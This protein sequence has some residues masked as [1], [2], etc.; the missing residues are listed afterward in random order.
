M[1][2]STRRR[3]AGT[4]G[5][6]SRRSLRSRA[7]TATAVAALCVPGVVA[8]APASAAAPAEQS[9]AQA[10]AAAPGD[11]VS[12]EPTE[13]KVF[14][15]PTPTHAWKIQYTSTDVHG[16]ANTVSGTVL[17]PQTESDGPRPLVTYALGTVGIGDH[18]A[19]SAQFAEGTASEA[20]LIEGALLRGWAVAV[21]DYEGLG[22]PGTHTYTVGRAAGTAVL[23]AARAAQR[24]PEAQEK[25]VTADSPVGIMGYSQ[26][27]QASGWAAELSSTYA[28]ELKVKGTASGGVPADLPKVAEYNDGDA[29]AG[30]VLM[31]AIGHDAAYPELALDSYLNDEGKRIT[32]IMRDG[33][34]KEAREAGANKSIEDVT[35]SDPNQEP[36]WQQRLAEDKLGTKAPG[37]PVYVYHGEGDEI[38]PHEVG[39][40]LRADW[41]AKGSTV[42]WKSYPLAPHAGTA[43]LA[44]IPAMNW[45]RDRFKGEATEGNCGS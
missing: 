22:T 18:C 12:S 42:Q 15:V 43:I 40:Q 38:I 32:G 36:D 14:G 23:D 37:H 17:V 30:L 31:S 20:A 6:L 34:L 44:S 25:G 45:L 29:E 21:T 3:G 16:K 10:A 39:A 1:Q 35:V 7:V 2:L 13:F 33:C 26:G 41:C 28:P 8:A 19:P 5:A 27:G 4:T 11:V 9:A 24:L